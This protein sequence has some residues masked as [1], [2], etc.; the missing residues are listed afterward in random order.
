MDAIGTGTIVVDFQVDGVILPDLLTTG[1]IVVDFDV[2]GVSINPTKTLPPSSM[3]PT[4]DQNPGVNDTPAVCFLANPGSNLRWN[5]GSIAWSYSG[6]PT[7]GSLSW[8]W[9]L[10]GVVKTET[11][12]IDVGGP[13]QFL[14]RLPKIFPVGATVVITL[15][16]AGAVK[17]SVYPA[18]YTSK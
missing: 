5:I 11:Y 13:G 8:S 17:G 9:Y 16:A 18:A 3:Q 6:A 4:A 10:D 12:A 1:T 2:S 14:F 7:A 15:A